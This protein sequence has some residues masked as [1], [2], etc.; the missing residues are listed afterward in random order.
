MM[1][2]RERRAAQARQELIDLVDEAGGL[3][4][5]VRL[6][7]VHRTTITRW[8]LGETR[9]PDAALISLRAAAR[10]QLP[11]QNMSAWSEWRFGEDGKLYDPSNRG[12]VPGDLLAI[13]LNHAMVM[14]QRSTIAELEDKLKRALDALDRL[15]PAANERRA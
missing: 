4:S 14:A 15:A 2:V 5:A 1:N 13:P 11:H 10:R 8:M 12:Y 6:L 3:M 7:N 9:V